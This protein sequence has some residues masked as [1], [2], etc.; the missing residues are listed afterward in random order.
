PV[1]SFGIAIAERDVLDTISPDL[2]DGVMSAV[3][4]YAFAGHEELIERMR[5]RYGEP[6]MTQNA[7]ST[8]GDMWIFKQALE[9]AGEASREAVAEA[10]RNMNGGPAKYFPGGVLAFDE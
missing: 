10:L 2:L 6:W 4:N 5:E 8:Y 9:E 1:I 3:G 7:I